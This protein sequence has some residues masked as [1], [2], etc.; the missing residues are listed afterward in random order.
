MGILIGLLILSLLVFVHELGHFLFA[1][2]AGVRVET[3][4]IGFGPKLIGYR[5][6]ETEYRISAIPFGGYVKMTGQDDMGR[7]KEKTDD[8]KDYRSKTIIQRIQIAFAGPLFNYL[9]ALIALTILYTTGIREAPTGA[10]VVGNI[11]DSSRGLEASFRTGDTIISINGKLMKDWEDVSIEIALKPEKKLD[12]MIGRAIGRDV[13]KLFPKKTGR[14]GMGTSGLSRNEPIIISEVVPGSPAEK[15]GIKKNDT[16]FAINGIRIPGWDFVVEKIAEAE[17]LAVI[18]TVKRGMEPLD[19]EVKPIYNK[20][21]KRYMIGIRPGTIL[22]V[23]KYPLQQAVVKAF[24]HTMNDAFMI[25]RSLKALATTQVS[26][27]GMAG[28]IG[29]VHITGQV[30]KGGFDMFLLFLAMI[31]VNLAVV[32]LFPFLIITDGGVIFFLLIEAL[33][34]KPMSDRNQMR[35]QQVAMF[36]IIALFLLL[37]WNDIFRLLGEH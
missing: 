28:P 19:L 37:T 32:N 25:W 24:H 21:N 33:R 30:A 34:G 9:L 14:E 6:G 8:S 10:P 31:S 3:F 4:S 36:G 17:S 16:L 13:L 20:E 26:V 5:I 15:A 18:I 12:V 2:K 22:V 1:K 7:I 35:I 23:N 27:K 29:I 11:A